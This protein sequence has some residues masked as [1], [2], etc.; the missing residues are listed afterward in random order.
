MCNFTLKEFTDD[1]WDWPQCPRDP[2][3]NKTVRK[4][5]SMKNLQFFFKRF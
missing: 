2:Y 4:M 3:E 1:S 5:K